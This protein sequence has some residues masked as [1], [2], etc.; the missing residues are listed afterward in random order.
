[1]PLPLHTHTQTP[2]NRR[3]LFIHSG[4]G[5]RI[6]AGDISSYSMSL[7]FECVYEGRRN[8]KIE[9]PKLS[10]YNFIII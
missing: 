4:P 8:K 2:K 1:M 7:I 5:G 3:V 10:L 6:K 9:R